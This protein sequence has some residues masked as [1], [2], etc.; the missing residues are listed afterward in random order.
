MYCHHFPRFLIFLLYKSWIAF[1]DPRL[2]S[3]R[4]T[5]NI[6]ILS[7]KGILVVRIF[8]SWPVMGNLKWSILILAWFQDLEYKYLDSCP[9]HLK[10]YLALLCFQWPKNIL[11]TVI[12][13]LCKLKRTKLVF[14]IV[15]LPQIR[16]KFP[17]YNICLICF[18]QLCQIIYIIYIL[19]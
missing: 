10:F 7:R 16:I 13:V 19:Y 8:D 5:E 6:L 4:V 14:T 17:L 3:R 15:Y 9:D 2:P 1:F 12:S 18:F 11:F